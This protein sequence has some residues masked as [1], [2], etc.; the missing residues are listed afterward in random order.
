MIRTTA[1]GPAL[2]K[3]VRCTTQ[4]MGPRARAGRA[5]WQPQRRPASPPRHIL[6]TPSR[7]KGLAGFFQR[8]GSSLQA[9]KIGFEQPA[10]VYRTAR[11]TATDSLALG[12]RAERTTRQDQGGQST[13]NDNFCLAQRL[14]DRNFAITR[15]QTMSRDAVRM[16]SKLPDS[17]STAS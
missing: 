3:R 17:Q 4:G 15:R 1:F 5:T 10:R 8:E 12:R 11:L 2:T 14:P 16:T 6:K 9:C 13:S 7:I